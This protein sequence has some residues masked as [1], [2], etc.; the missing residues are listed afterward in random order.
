MANTI[1]VL[2]DNAVTD[3]IIER[4]ITEIVDD[5]LTSIGNYVFYNCSNLTTANFPAVTT[6]GGSA[7][8]SCSKLTT[9]NFPAVTSS[10]GS[11]AFYDCSNLTT[12][13][14][15]AVTSIGNSVF[16]SCSKLTTV[17]F[18]AVT[19]IGDNAFSSCSN[20]TTANFPA[21]TSISSGA[22]SGCT[23]LTTLILRNTE[24]VATLNS[25]NAF[26]NAA[27]CIIYVPDEL[28]DDY[29]TATNWSAY[30]YRIK[31]LSELPETE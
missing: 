11:S 13:N 18:P 28:V 15:P 27:N 10:I 29:K 3:S 30:A 14:F 25:T 7:F 23:K 1:D 12:A 19:I 20:L 24:K 31:G 26:N 16:S 22:F 2:G 17:D 9:A 21:V 8:S 6:I 4:S 5:V